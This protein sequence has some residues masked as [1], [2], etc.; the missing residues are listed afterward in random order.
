MREQW[1]GCLSQHRMEVVYTWMAM[2][3]SR[4]AVSEREM[5]EDAFRVGSSV[6]A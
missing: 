4:A 2:W 3:W 5:V 1:H 6:T